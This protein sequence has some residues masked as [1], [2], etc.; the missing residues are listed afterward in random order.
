MD[1]G[2]TIISAKR[3]M[4]SSATKYLSPRVLIAIEALKMIRQHNMTGTMS[5]FEHMISLYT[6]MLENPMW[7]Y[8]FL[9]HESKSDMIHR[10]LWSATYRRVV[11]GCDCATE[12]KCASSR[13][14]QSSYAQLEAGTDHLSHA[15][16]AL[17]P[18]SSVCP[19]KFHH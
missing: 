11:F 6:P 14:D 17:W 10:P 4:A 8:A 7:T 18:Q 5:P 19:P 12:A 9:F 13:E 15:S 3:C 16:M 1:N 2:I